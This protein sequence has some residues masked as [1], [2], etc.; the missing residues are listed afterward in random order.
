MPNNTDTVLSEQNKTVDCALA[1]HSVP[2]RL[3]GFTLVQSLTASEC[4]HSSEPPPSNEMKGGVR[5]ELFRIHI[6]SA[7]REQNGGRR[8]GE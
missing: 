5:S 7:G 8:W 4:R 2:S 3:I 1:S 6:C